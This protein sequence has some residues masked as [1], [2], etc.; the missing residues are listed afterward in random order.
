VAPQVAPPAARPSS[1][2]PGYIYLAAADGSIAAR[3][4]AGAWPARSPDGR[5][6]AFHRDGEGTAHVIDVDGANEIRLAH[7]ASP[8]WSPD[9]ARIAFTSG[10][11]I[12]VMRADGSDL[13]LLTVF[14]DRRRYAESDP[15]WSPDGT[16]I[17][18]TGTAAR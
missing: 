10:E 13:P 15:S 2:E 18:F 11:G 17:A 3:L 4:T 7:G 14:P 9:G 8:S 5:R 16:R 6:I 1:T 12:S